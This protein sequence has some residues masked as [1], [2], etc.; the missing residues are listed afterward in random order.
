MRALDN[1]EKMPKS[2]FQTNSA[3]SRS[4]SWRPVLIALLW[5]LLQLPSEM[6]STST[7]FFRMVFTVCFNVSLKI[8]AIFKYNRS[9]AWGRKLQNKG[10]MGKEI[11]FHPGAILEHDFLIYPMIIT[12]SLPKRD[13]C[14]L[15]QGH[16]S[17]PAKSPGKKKLSQN[18]GAF[19]H[20]S[21]I[22]RRL[23][24]FIQEYLTYKLERN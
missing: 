13:P 3:E 17:I 21:D 1:K 24:H 11:I 23:R 22:Q 12:T 19:L 20:L 9:S 8:N 6:N 5:W 7:V 18:W 2:G 16:T 14:A 10:K 15:N 4:Q